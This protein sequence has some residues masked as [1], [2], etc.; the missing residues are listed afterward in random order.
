[1]YSGWA[2]DK[3]GRKLSIL[4]SGVPL[5]LGWILIASASNINQ[6]YAARVIFGLA[7]GQLFTIVPMYVGEI[8][9]VIYLD[10]FLISTSE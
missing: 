10:I 8:A 9:E 2:A 4:A 1:M 3:F 5:L 7:V 6:I